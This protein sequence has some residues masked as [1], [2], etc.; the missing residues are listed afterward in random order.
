MLLCR[1]VVVGFLA[2]ICFHDGCAVAVCALG[3]HK[4]T[5]GLSGVRT[6]K[7]ANV[8]CDSKEGVHVRQIETSIA[9]RP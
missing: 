9:A 7:N 2:T 1:T 8:K 3:V 6:T 4:A 5:E